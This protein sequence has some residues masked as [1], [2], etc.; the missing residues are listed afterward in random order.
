MLKIKTVPVLTR[1]IAKL[2][3]K[4]VISILKNTDVFGEAKNK[5]E[6]LKELKGEGAAELGFE[7]LGAITPQLDRIGE[8]IPEFVSLYKGVSLEEAGEFDLA[9]IVNEVIHDEGITGFF[10]NALRKKAEPEH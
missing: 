4:P 9:E 8:D 3:L 10:K 7:I 2:D 5:A 1:I 6:A